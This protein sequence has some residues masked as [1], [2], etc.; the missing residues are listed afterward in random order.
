MKYILLFILFICSSNII[1]AQ[2]T[3]STRYGESILVKVIEVG[4]AE[5]KYK[6]LDNLN[7]PMFS[8]LK[9]DLLMIKYE[10]GTNED[11]SKEEKTKIKV[12]RTHNRLIWGI[13]GGVLSL[14]SLIALR[15]VFR[16]MNG[17]WG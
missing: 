2:D 16:N 10:N 3:L 1:K 7:G 4:T 14:V 17:G 15:S 6:K 12:K 9:S 13:V 5:V 11:F 8:M